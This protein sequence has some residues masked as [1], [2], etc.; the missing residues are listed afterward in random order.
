[1]G[2]AF[3]EHRAMT[4]TVVPATL[5]GQFYLGI[6]GGGGSSDNVN[7]IQYGT[8]FFP[9]L[10]GGPLAVNGFGPLKNNGTGWFGGAQLGYQAQG[11]SLPLNLYPQ[12]TFGPA[13]E[14]EGYWFGNRTL[15]GDAINNTARLPE[16]D[17]EL[18]FSANRSI[19]LTNFVLNLN[20]PCYLFHPYVGFGIG[21]ALV[22]LSGADSTQISP[23]EPGVNHFNTK[24]SDTNATF[25]GQIKAGLAYDINEWVSI[26]A[27]YRWLYLSSTQFTFGSTVYPTHV[28]TS[29]WQVKV[30]PQNYN[31][32][33]IG[34]RFNL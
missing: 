1:M 14:I 4:T 32:G 30:A 2:S 20:N 25:A 15:H 24:T 34:L 8:A 22:R 29:S 27:E 16:H 21:G 33:S 26:Y 28:P 18:S 31:L 23:I 10:V 17:F 6:F 7:V 3:A 12:W 5:P 13:F 19:Y 9:D 11:V